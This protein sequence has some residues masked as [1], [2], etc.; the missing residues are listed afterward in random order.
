MAL[1]I[2]YLVILDMA[3]GAMPA[4]IQEIAV[5]FQVLSFSG[6]DRAVRGAHPV[7]ALAIIGGVWLTIGLWRVRRLES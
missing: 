3:I 4:S 5:S 1:S 6:L 7:I 2:L